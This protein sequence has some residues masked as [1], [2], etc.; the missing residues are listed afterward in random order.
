MVCSRIGIMNGMENKVTCGREEGTKSMKDQKMGKK[1]QEEETQIDL[2]QLFRGTWKNLR[3]FWWLAALLVLIGAVGF[4]VFQLFCRKLMYESS[5]TFT[6]ATESSAS[7]NYGFYYNNETAAQ[8]SNTFPYILESNYFQSTLLERLDEDTLNGTITSETITNSNVVTMKVQSTDPQDAYAILTA[9]IEIYPETAHFV[10][11]DISFEM[12]TE[13]K[14]PKEPYNQIGFLRSIGIGAVAGFMIILVFCGGL[15]LFRKNVCDTEDMKRITSSRCLARIPHVRVKVRS[16]TC[17][18]RTLFLQ[19]HSS[20]GYQESIRTLVNRIT[21]SMEEEEGK[22]LLVS[23]TV[24]GE[25]KSVTAVNLALKLGEDGYQVLLIDGDLRKQKN[26]ELI[27]VQ[28]AYGLEDVCTWDDEETAWEMI[29]KNSQEIGRKGVCFLGKTRRVAQPASVLTSE[30]IRMFL[31]A[32]RKKVDYIIIDSPP[33]VMFQDASILAEY[34]DAV[35][36]VVRYDQLPL[37]KIRYGI[38]SLGGKKNKFLGY[39]FN[40]CPETSGRYGYG[41]Y[42]YGKYSYGR[43]GYGR[44]GYRRSGKKEEEQ[45][46]I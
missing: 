11:G 3:R 37:D 30:K 1:R 32:M 10:L 7:G 24:A 12:L 22:I 41:Q 17:D 33:C 2:F 9:A 25:G 20:Y 16:K 26:E 5:A 40:D 34:S 39:V 45:E 35:L 31:E 6:V 46:R 15:A 27:G 38:A 28:A 21:R 18:Q 23:S 19:G 43:Y 14:V 42:S 44:D 29:Q 8:L 36:Y 13:P 4:S